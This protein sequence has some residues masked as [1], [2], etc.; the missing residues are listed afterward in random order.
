MG[1]STPPSRGSLSE[2]SKAVN[3][4]SLCLCTPFEDTTCFRCCPPIRPAGYDHLNYISSLKR[5]FRENRVRFLQKKINLG[6]VMGFFCWG[7]GYLD[8]RGRRVGCLLHPAVHNG[9]DL[10]YLTGYGDKCRREVC[11]QAKIFNELPVEAR[12]F[13][14]EMT[15][16]LSSFYFS[17][18][19][20]NPL[21]HVLLW[22]ESI[23]E[24][25][26]EYASGNGLSCTEL[27]WNFPFLAD[28]KISPRKWKYPILK[29]IDTLPQREWK[30]FR[31]DTFFEVTEEEISSKKQRFWHRLVCRLCKIFSRNEP[32]Q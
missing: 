16:G 32:L 30:D 23:L 25:M 19:R 2:S 10:R 6:P 17:S 22:G 24:A 26:F 21:F 13:W 8:D 3:E 15:Q 18:E 29:I 20:A 14:L 11:L 27:V 1:I 31:W 12:R 9:R 4:Q 5:E 7:L 28:P